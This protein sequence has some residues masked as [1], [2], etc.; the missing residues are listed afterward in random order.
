MPS[1]CLLW[2]DYKA[3]FVLEKLDQEKEEIYDENVQKEL[4]RQVTNSLKIF[5][6]LDK[7]WVEKAS[8]LLG[9]QNCRTAWI[10]SCLH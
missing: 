1:D 2:L 9:V 7:T 6:E 10:S 8:E 4:I 3:S 5:Y